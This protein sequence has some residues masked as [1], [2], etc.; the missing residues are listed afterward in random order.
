MKKLFKK[1]FPVVLVAAITMSACVSEDDQKLPNFS[2]VYGEDFNGADNVPL[3]I[4]G[5]RN[6]AEAG[7]VLWKT[8]QYSGNGYAEFSGYQ[9]GESSNIGWLISPAISLAEG[10]NKVLR[11]QSS[12]AYVSSSANSLQVLISTNYDETNVLSATWTPIQANLPTVDSNYFEF[13]D[14]GEISLQNYTGNIYV[15]FRVVSSGT[16][17]TLD[18]SYQI[19]S[20][21]VY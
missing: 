8:Q 5:W 6:F 20:F 19:D 18:G 11:F 4:N 12:Q 17:T 15:A 16:S 21:R 14:S 10:H 1:C 7:T 9:S 13:I 2:L 3:A